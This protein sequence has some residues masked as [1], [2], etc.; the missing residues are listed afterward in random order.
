MSRL[1]GNYSVTLKFG[2]EVVQLNPMTSEKFV[3]TQDMNSLLPRLDLRFKDPAGVLTHVIPFDRNMSRIRVEINSKDGEEIVNSFDFIVFRRMPQAAFTTSAYYEVS[4]LLDVDKV[5]SPS[6]CR[7]FDQSIKTT[8]GEIAQDELGCERME[9]ENSLDYAKHLIQP[10][11]N[12]TQ[13][14]NWLKANLIG[15]NDEYGYKIF[16]RM[17]DNYRNFVA[18]SLRDM[19][20]GEPVYKF[21]IADKPYEDLFPVYDYEAYDNYRY[22]GAFGSKAQNYGYFDYTNSEFAEGDLSIDDFMSLTRY[23]MIDQADSDESASVNIGN[24]SNEFTSD[25]KGPM[26]ARYYG[27]MSGLSKMWILTNGIEN[28]SPGD[29]VSVFFPQGAKSTSDVFSYQ[30]NGNWLTERVVHDFGHTFRTRLLL[31]R[32]GLDTDKDTTLVPAVTRNKTK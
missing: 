12:N 26:M 4:A 18:W 5:F 27:R 10:S 16:I 13:F 30:Y 31:T 1:V 22:F 29:M 25:F 6:Y 24:R 20:F 32:N 15:R 3:I 11:W 7:S 14:F 9:I 17:K 2:D 28:I 8:L 21:V 19:F 23:H